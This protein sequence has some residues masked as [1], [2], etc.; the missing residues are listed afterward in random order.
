M[1]LEQLVQG[2]AEETGIQNLELNRHGLCQFTLD[3]GLTVTLEDA[4]PERCA[5]VYAVIARVPETGVEELYATLLSAQLFGRGT[6]DGCAFGLDRATGEI[7]FCT[8]MFP[9][10]LDAPAFSATL[11]EFINWAEHWRSTLAEQ[12][13]P[14]ASEAADSMPSHL[15]RA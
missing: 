3:G 10:D 15:I 7:L 8:R 14:A 11:N 5:H 13:E 2:L 1:S 9:Q 6:G 12:P 4:P